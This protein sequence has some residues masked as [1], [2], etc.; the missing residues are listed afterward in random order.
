MT[1]ANLE[2]ATALGRIAH[3]LATHEATPVPDADWMPGDPLW[4]HPDVRRR[5]RPWD[6]EAGVVRPMFELLDQP[7]RSRCGPC[8]VSWIGSD[9]CWMCG[10]PAGTPMAAA[11]SAA[12]RDISRI[13]SEMPTT[14]VE[15]VRR[16]FDAMQPEPQPVRDPRQRALDARRNR[17][18]G[19]AARRLDGRRA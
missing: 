9:P 7:T 13:M 12:A 1:T 3:M 10:T 18:T 2:A 17:G 4:D 8:E 14:T 11:F 6:D 16:A 15:A 19:P 5:A